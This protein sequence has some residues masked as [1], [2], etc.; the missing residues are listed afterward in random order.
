MK[1]R[2]ERRREEKRRERARESEKH[3]KKNRKV[4]SNLTVSCQRARMSQLITYRRQR[5]ALVENTCVSFQEQKT[6]LFK[7]LQ[8][9]EERQGHRRDL[10]F[11]RILV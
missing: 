2:E 5:K 4:V 9:E 3:E 10:Y 11:Q 8:I 1:R 6:I 7:Y